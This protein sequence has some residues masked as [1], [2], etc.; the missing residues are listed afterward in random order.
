MEKKEM[1][2]LPAEVVNDDLLQEVVKATASTVAVPKRDQN[3]LYNKVEASTSEITDKINS[4]TILTPADADRLAKAKAFV[5]STYTDVPEYRPLVVKM[6][7]VLNDGQFPTPDSKFWQC[8]KEAEVHFNQM[9]GEVFKYERSLVDIE[10]M[11]YMIAS[12]DKALNEKL[13]PVDPM[14]L[15]FEVRRLRIKREEYLFSMKRLEKSIKFRIQEVVE[16]A[17]IANS[18]EASCKYDTKDYN[19]H[20]TENMY[21][22]LKNDVENA[23]DADTKKMYSSQLATLERLLKE[24]LSQ[25]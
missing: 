25:K 8:K 3:A 19:A 20:I 11:D 15:S 10:E 24:R 21:K 5:L 16:W 4:L 12:F 18:V 6:A 13:T 17:A 14:K 2:A 7:S 9:V 22:K 1:S 23:G